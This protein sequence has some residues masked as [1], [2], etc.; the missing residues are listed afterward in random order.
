GGGINPGENKLTALKRECLEEIGC[1]IEI[2]AELGKIIEYRKMWQLQQISY[3][4]LAKITGPK[5][6]SNFTKK[7]LADGFQQL[8]LPY[9]KALSLVSTNQA[10]NSEGKNYI[11]PRDTL[12]LELAKKYF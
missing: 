8:W 5:G 10:L 2:T 7:E 1:E 12:I 11:V 6:L 3:C 9:P 4:Y